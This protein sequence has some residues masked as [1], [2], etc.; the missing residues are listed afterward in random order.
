MKALV[1]HSWKRKKKMYLYD[2]RD[3]SD[4]K[5]VCGIGVAANN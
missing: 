4:G 3:L 1:T 2:F 5:F